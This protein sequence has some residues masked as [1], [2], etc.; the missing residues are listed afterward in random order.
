MKAG[1]FPGQG[2]DARA[3]ADALPAGHQLLRK[4]DEVLGYDLRRSVKGTSRA[5]MQTRIAQPAILVAGL[6]SFCRAIGEGQRFDYLAGHSLGEY[7]ALVASGA[8]RFRDGVRLVSARAEA[9]QRAARRAPGG[10]AVVLG[11]DA[12]TV[13]DLARRAGATVA[14]DN[15]PAQ[16]VVAGDESSLT[17]TAMLTRSEGGRCIRLSVEGPFHTHAMDTALDDLAE[18]LV[19]TEIH[20]PRIPVVSNVSA[21][22]YRAPGEIRKLLLEQ[23]TGRVRFRESIEWLASKGVTEFVDFGPSRVAEGIARATVARTPAVV[24][25]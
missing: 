3:V 20:L 22:P 17:R 11:L 9:M 1:L 10:M 2:L 6:I 14:N 21:V 16:Q 24:D 13:D 18:A 19:R 23:L 7:T 8:I 5:T 4:A 25:G 12:E 15:S